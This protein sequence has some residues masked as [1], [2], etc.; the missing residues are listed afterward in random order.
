MVMKLRCERKGTMAADRLHLFVASDPRSLGQIRPPE[1]CCRQVA[2]LCDKGKP[3][4]AAGG[5]GIII[6]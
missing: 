6:L 4:T 5:G 2:H 3:P 1:A